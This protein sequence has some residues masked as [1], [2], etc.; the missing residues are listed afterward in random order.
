MTAGE[1]R[2]DMMEDVSHIE[3]LNPVTLW[4]SVSVLM[5][6]LDRISAFRALRRKICCTDWTYRKGDFH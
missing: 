1:R 3:T 2:G 4:F 5:G 6:E